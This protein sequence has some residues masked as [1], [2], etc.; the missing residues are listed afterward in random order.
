MRKF[1]LWLH[2]K[3]IRVSIP[4]TFNPSIDVSKYSEPKLIQLRA[5]CKA[6]IDDGSLAEV[7]SSRANEIKKHITLESPDYHD[8]ELNRVKLFEL[9]NLSVEISRL[10]KPKREPAKFDKNSIF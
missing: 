4:D 1:V 5:G 3:F 9:S 10:A 2:R 8:V 6:I 7:I